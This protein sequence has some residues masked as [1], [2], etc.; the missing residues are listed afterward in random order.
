MFPSAVI[1]AQAAPP[2]WGQPGIVITCILLAIP[3]AVGLWLLGLKIGASRRPSGPDR[4]SSDE[5][6]AADMLTVDKRDAAPG[7][8]SSGLIRN[9]DQ[10]GAIRFIPAKK[11]A[12]RRP[13]IHRP[14]A[15]LILWY[16][17]AATLWL[18]FGTTIGEYLGI[19]FVAPDAGP[20]ELAE[21]RPLRPVHTNAVFW[22]WAS[23]AMIG[24]GLLR[25]GKGGNVRLGLDPGR[26]VDI[27]TDERRRG[28]R[29]HRVDGR[30]QQ[31]RR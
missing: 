8:S 7:S 28:A 1:V 10:S 9:V 15:Q 5:L 2:L 6:N 24:L 20:P 11:P 19:K 21:F 29:E 22:G 30:H 26:L 23:L 31:W 16:L 27:R 18:L 25:R 13:E 17:G 3:M 4:D 12:L 14:L